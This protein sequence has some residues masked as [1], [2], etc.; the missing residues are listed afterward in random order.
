MSQALRRDL[1]IIADW[2]QPGSRVLDLGCG[3]GELLSYLQKEKQVQGYGIE[4][5][6]ERVAAALRRGIPVIQ[7]DLDSG[8]RQ[9]ASGSVDTVVLS[10]TLQAVYYPRDL[11]LEMLRVGRE[12]IVTF[13]NM[14]HWRARWQFGVKGRMPMTDVLPHSWYDTPNIHLCTI[15][16]FD[17]LCRDNRIE[18][19]ERVVLDDRRR[20]TQSNRIWPNL[21][22][23]VALYRCTRA[24]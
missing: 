2:I 5:D 7:Q 12:G 3:E 17:A 24:D 19:R 21:L 1:Q 11:L 14:G 22:G 9:F 23:E 6:D 10:L 4:V 15:R 16:D 13:P 20:S 8:L 18:V